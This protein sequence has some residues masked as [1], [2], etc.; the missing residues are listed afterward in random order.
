MLPVSQGLA[1]CG[2]IPIKT[3]CCLDRKFSRYLYIYRNEVRLGGL[4]RI[5][6]SRPDELSGRHATTFPPLFANLRFGDC[7]LA[8]I[9][10][11]R[12]L[13]RYVH[14]TRPKFGGAGLSRERFPNSST[15]HADA[16]RCSG[17]SCAL[18]ADLLR[19]YYR[20]ASLVGSELF[21]QSVV[22]GC[23]IL[24]RGR[25]WSGRSYTT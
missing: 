6:E 15:I 1:P 12:S 21:W 5:C 25:K 2:I 10:T 4:S 19:E 8:R 3:Q 7:N 23:R 17:S 13:A 14:R 18:L 11:A 9:E 24:A 22:P 20:P 16:A